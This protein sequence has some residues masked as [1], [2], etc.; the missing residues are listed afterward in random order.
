[1]TEPSRSL[2]PICAVRGLNPVP[3]CKP[4]PAT[5]S[6]RTS[7]VRS[8]CRTTTPVGRMK[9]P[10]RASRAAN[11]TAASPAS[12]NRSA[13]ADT[14]SREA[15]HSSRA[16]NPLNPPTYSVNWLPLRKRLGLAT[17]RTVAPVPPRQAASRRARSESSSRAGRK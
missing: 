17:T 9:M 16:P 14:Q 12:A 1:M 5:S 13:P 11:A 3:S 8:V 15:Y 7:R 6:Q 4:A 2:T 10:V